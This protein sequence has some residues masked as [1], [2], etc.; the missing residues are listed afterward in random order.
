MCG[1][2]NYIQYSMINTMENNILKRVYI[3]IYITESLCCTS[4]LKS[5]MLQFLQTKNVW[6][7][8]NYICF[9]Y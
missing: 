5:T 2:G 6:H 8:F 7:L 4:V 3:Y 1:T 9:R